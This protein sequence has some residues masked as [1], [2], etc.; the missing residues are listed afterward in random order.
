VPVGVAEAGAWRYALYE[1]LDRWLPNVAREARRIRPDAARQYLAG[2][3]LDSVGAAETAAVRSLFQW[4]RTDAV[5]AL[6]TLVSHGAALRLEDGRWASSRV[7]A[8]SSRRP[9]G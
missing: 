8:G 3:Y 6:E 4:D 5:T 1:L 2:L 9:R 7:L